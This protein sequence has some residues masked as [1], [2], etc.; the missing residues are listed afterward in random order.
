MSIEKSNNDFINA[1][2]V[3]SLRIANYQ[4]QLKDEIL[5]ISE[6]IVSVLNSDKKI[7]LCGNGGSA[8]DSQHAA[9]EFVGRFKYDRKPLAAIALST[10]TSIITSIS[11]DYGFDFIFSKQIEAIGSEGDLLI[12]IS[13]S[14]KSKNILKA[15]DT[16][17]KRKIITISI[18]GENTSSVK[19]LSDH[20]ISIPSNETGVIQQ[21]H[22]TILQ[23][24]A[25]LVENSLFTN[26]NL[27]NFK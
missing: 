12:A 7:L 9:A 8:S 13:T 15:L 2:L 27:K 10:D 18:V 26:H 6:N 4:F 25:G 11:N 1:Y 24:I 19:N 22:I 21:S 16:A 20:I 23:L 14:G 3:E 5:S 17:K